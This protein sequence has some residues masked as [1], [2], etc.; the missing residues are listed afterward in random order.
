MRKV[1]TIKRTVLI[2]GFLF[3]MPVLLAAQ[4]AEEIVVKMDDLQR[5]DSMQS[6]GSLI[7][8][9]RF[10][11]KTITFISWSEGSSDFLIEFTSAAEA[12][13]KI[14]RTSDEL[15]L[16]FPDA[17]EVIR[18][19]GAALRQSMMGSDIS[20]EDMTEGNNTLDKYDV[21]LVGEE[22]VEGKN[23]FVIEMT[24]KSRNVPYTKQTI[25]VVKDSYIPQQVQY[26]SKSG[27]L[28]KEM[29]VLGF[30]EVDGKVIISRM[31]LEDKLK[32][33][34]STEMILDEAKAN[35]K[36]AS[37]FFSLDQLSW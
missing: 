26:F 35:I 12:G 32:K 18:L 36:L 37:D 23:C 17:E 29:R 9:D 6:R 8:R 21:K 31:V 1:K 2:L 5:F 22:R 19:Q 24:A 20:Y 14:L 7:T 4:T 11:T 25:W 16:Y 13:Q 3:L 30:M 27:K 28:L 34:S 33:N 10:G 15:F